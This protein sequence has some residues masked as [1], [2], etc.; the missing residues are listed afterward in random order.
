MSTSEKPKTRRF[1]M[2]LDVSGALKNWK[3][4]GR[5]WKGVVTDPETGRV[6]TPSEFQNYLL[7]QLAQGVRRIPFE[8]KTSKCEG[9]SPET[10]CPGHEIEEE[11]RG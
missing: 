5:E 1:H 3:R 9:F 10:G 2:S 6:L 4:G 11:P 8:T 7:E